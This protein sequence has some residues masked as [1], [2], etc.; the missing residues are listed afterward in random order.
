MNQKRKQYDNLIKS[1]KNSPA[2]GG[3]PDA[4]VQSKR[5]E[6]LNFR[7]NKTLN[8]QRNSQPGMSA[9]PHFQGIRNKTEKIDRQSQKKKLTI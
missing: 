4:R 1:R 5:P 6:P 3:S 2:L 9:S 8:V 7:S